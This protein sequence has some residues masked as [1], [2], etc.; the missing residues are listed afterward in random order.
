MQGRAS[1]AC[2]SG[3]V[4]RQ[5][6][7]MQRTVVSRAIRFSAASDSVFQIALHEQAQHG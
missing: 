3:E 6:A 4:R 5:R 1:D 2:S 7:A